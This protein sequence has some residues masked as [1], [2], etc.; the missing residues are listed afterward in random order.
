MKCAICRHGETRAGFITVT[1]ER[2]PTILVFKN[3]PAQVCRSC[4]EEYLSA[5][6][7]QKLLCRAE[8]E[9]SRGVELELLQYAA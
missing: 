8:E 2:G 3:V 9:V 7:N 4:G 6:D 5:E 1:L